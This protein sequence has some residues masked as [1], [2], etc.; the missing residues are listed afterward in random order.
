MGLKLAQLI[1]KAWE[2]DEFIAVIVYGP[3]RIGKTAYSLKVLAEVMGKNGVPDYSIATAKR[4]LVF[5]PK[6]FL[7]RVESITMK[8]PMIVWDDAGMW[9]YALDWYDPWVKAVAK[10]LNVVGTD[11]AA[12]IFTTPLPTWVISKLRGLPQVITIKIIKTGASHFARRA[13][14]Y[15]SW[16]APDMKKTGVRKIFYD[17][18]S[19]KLPDRLYRWYH[20]IRKGYADEAKSM[21]RGL[22]EKQDKR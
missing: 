2:N 20:P 13:T 9:L 7:E 6:Q 19:C 12:V 5:P 17:N 14:A 10:Y 3:Q 11:L 8:E 1:R 22:L 18:F 21:M 4:N 15:R 16:M